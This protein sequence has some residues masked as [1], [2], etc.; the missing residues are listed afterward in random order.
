M[1]KLKQDVL[2]SKQ[3]TRERNKIVK[4]IKDWAARNKKVFWKYEVS[5]FYK[6]Y[7][8]KV[9]NLP[10]PSADDVMLSSNNRL[11]NDQQ[12]VQLCN[13]LKKTCSKAECLSDSSIDVQ[14]DY[15][16][17]EVVAEAV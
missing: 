13:A 14:I 11:L 2:E 16:D 9:S 12:R 7:I 5:C 6:T 8:I 4:T 10:E 15:L 3:A 17:G 1:S